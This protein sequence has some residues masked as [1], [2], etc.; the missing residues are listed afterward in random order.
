MKGMGVAMLLFML[1]NCL[2]DT[3]VDYSTIWSHLP[4]QSGQVQKNIFEQLRMLRKTVSKKS[5]LALAEKVSEEVAKIEKAAISRSK[6]NFDPSK[7][8]SE[9]RSR[10][11]L[12]YALSMLGENAVRELLKFHGLSQLFDGFI[13]RIRVDQPPGFLFPLR[14]A[15]RR[16][17]DKPGD[18]LFLCSDANTIR[19]V[20]EAKVQDVKIVA[21][22]VKPAEVRNI[23][24]AKPD[25]FL[26]NLHEVI[27][28]IDLGLT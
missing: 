10:G 21:L 19:S 9:V 7:T 11:V 26:P 28:L 23:I 24:M 3:N 13:P 1:E 12:V 16:L 18:V 27:D 5:Y 2:I 8:L 15:K 22:P 4:R 20:R 6:L 14:V 17:K 25:I